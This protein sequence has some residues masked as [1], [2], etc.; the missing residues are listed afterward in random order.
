[1]NKVPDFMGNVPAIP[2]DIYWDKRADEAYPTWRKNFE[3]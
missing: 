2:T 3:E 1:M